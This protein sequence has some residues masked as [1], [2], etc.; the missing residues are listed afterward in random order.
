MKK[1]AMLLCLVSA[2]VLC[3][4]AFASEIVLTTEL[5][6]YRGNGAY[7]AIYLT[8]EKGRYQETLWVAGQKS[9]YYKHLPGW[10]RGSRLRSS[11]YD[12]L[13]GASVT[14]GKTLT[15]TIDLAD[16]YIDSGYQIRVD[17][18]VE[19]MRD[20]RNDVIVSLTTA[21]VGKPVDGRGYVKAFTY[22][23]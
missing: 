16:S 2:S 21:G 11:E 15:V 8:D 12:G 13:T 5:K 3:N 14:K 18:A 23:F 1:I 7:L 22:S 4:Q 6:S 10:A 19:D 20:N 9:K 17:S